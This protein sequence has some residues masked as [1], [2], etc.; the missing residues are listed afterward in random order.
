METIY[1][2]ENGKSVVLSDPKLQVKVYGVQNNK[3]KTGSI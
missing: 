2:S 1:P 3:P